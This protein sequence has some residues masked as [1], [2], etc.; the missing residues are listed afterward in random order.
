MW[1]ETDLLISQ[2]PFGLL[3]QPL[4]MD[5]VERGAVGVMS[6]KGNRSTRRKPAPV[7]LYPPQIPHHLI[8]PRTLAAAVGSR[9][10]TP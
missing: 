2:P 5:D 9:R 4:T 10:Q 7:S 3:Y 8:W 1:D 6:G